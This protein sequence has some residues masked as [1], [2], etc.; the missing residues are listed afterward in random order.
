MTDTNP[1]DNSTAASDDETPPGDAPAAVHRRLSD[2]GVR[3]NEAQSHLSAVRTQAT[4]SDLDDEV[5]LA[6]GQALVRSLE[7][8]R[9]RLDD[10]LVVAEELTTPDETD[11]QSSERPDEQSGDETGS[12]ENPDRRGSQ[13]LWNTVPADAPGHSR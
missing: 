9:E 1:S 12:D 6:E 13:L 8:C 7:E 3:L 11:D 5:A 10:A 4:R 2:A